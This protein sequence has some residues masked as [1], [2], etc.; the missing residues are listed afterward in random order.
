M[1]ATKTKNRI[2][3]KTMVNIGN[4]TTPLED[5]SKVLS[6]AAPKTRGRGRPIGSAS[7]ASIALSELN[8]ILQPN[9]AV[10]VS[11][12]FA[13]ALL[14]QAENLPAVPSAAAQS[15]GNPDGPV[16]PESEL[17]PQITEFSD[18]NPSGNPAL[19]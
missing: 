6:E 5:V 13:E 7:Y 2:K 17:R 10:L 4:N 15:N 1:S 9:A 19:E 11:R 3:K 16:A 14:L 18:E 12:K 8:K